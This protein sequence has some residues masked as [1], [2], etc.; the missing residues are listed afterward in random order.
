MRTPE[1]RVTRKIV[2][3]LW[4]LKQQVG[5]IKEIKEGMKELGITLD[6]P[7]NK[8][9]NFKELKNKYFNQIYTNDT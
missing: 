9:E 4:N 8:I 2:V 6:N 3:K 7:Q 1:T 5:W